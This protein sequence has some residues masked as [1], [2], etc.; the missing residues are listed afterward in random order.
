MFVSATDW[1]LVPESELPLLLE[2]DQVKLPRKRVA[3][4]PPKPRSLKCHLCTNVFSNKYHLKAHI[5]TH[6]NP[7]SCRICGK[8]QP[9]KSKLERHMLVHTQIKNFLCTYCDR[10]FTHDCN[11]KTHERVHTGEKPY[12]CTICSFSAAQIA[13]MRHHMKSKH[14]LSFP[15]ML[16]MKADAQVNVCAVCNKTF[17]C[18]IM[19]QMHMDQHPSEE[20]NKCPICKATFMY[21]YKLEKHISLHYRPKS[22]EGNDSKLEHT[23]KTRLLR[24]FMDLEGESC[25]TK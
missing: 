12:K 10:S 11:R 22:E 24:H 14:K 20:N 16:N 8:R 23:D 2:N 7:L 18:K 17:S 6:E 25:R 21:Q 5:K 4:P 15:E 19:L 1:L 9:D 13:N 3:E